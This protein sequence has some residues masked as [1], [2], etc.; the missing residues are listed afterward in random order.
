MQDIFG[1]AIHPIR[2]KRH[3]ARRF[4]LLGRVLNERQIDFFSTFFPPVYLSQITGTRSEATGREITGHLVACPLTP[5]QMLS[6]PLG[7]VYRKIIATGRMAERHGARIFGLGAYNS[8]VG[9]AGVSVAAGLAIPVTT[10]DS[11][12]VAVV[13]RAM[14]QAAVQMDIDLR[15]AAVAIVGAT[16]AIGAACTEW[17]A[18]EAGELIMIGRRVEALEAI[19]ERC[20]GRGAVLHTT[21]DLSAMRRADLILT[22]TS[23]IEPIVKSDYLRPGAVVCDVSQPR[24]VSREVAMQR[25]DVLVIEGGMVDVP[26]EVDFNFDIDLPPGKAYACVAETMALTLEG[27]YESFTLGKH[28]DVTRAKEID[29]I[30]TRHGFRVSGLRSFGQ[31]VT[32][33]DIAR[34]RQHAKRTARE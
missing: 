12:T 15:G 7:Y 24:D 4:P 14:Q 27:R 28:I 13:V 30:A 21:T 2:H 20:E 11:Y 26:G 22:A 23:A 25:P 16:G 17:L 19:R 5:H 34:I 31:V 10:G 8:I 1:F 32:D 33:E 3:V 6:L 29:A 18:E 9:D